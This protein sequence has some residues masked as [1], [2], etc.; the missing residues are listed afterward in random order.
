MKPA[1]IVLPLALFLAGCQAEAPPRVFDPTPRC[2][3]DR[4]QGLIGQDAVVLRSMRFDGPVRV[5][6][7]GMAVTMDYNPTR[8]NFEV[9]AAGV[10][11]RVW[12]S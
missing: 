7:P 12:C 9:D 5:I 11:R 1:V 8:L 4:L 6:H 2:G 3:A 10:I